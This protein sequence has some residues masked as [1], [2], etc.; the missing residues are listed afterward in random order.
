MQIEHEKR[1]KQSHGHF[2]KNMTKEEKK[3]LEQI[4]QE[5]KLLRVEMGRLQRITIIRETEPRYCPNI[6]VGTEPTYYYSGERPN[7]GTEP[8]YYSTTANRYW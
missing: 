1:E 7:T 5:L 8:R 4:L 2:K 6:R 3:L